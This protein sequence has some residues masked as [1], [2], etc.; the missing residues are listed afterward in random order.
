MAIPTSRTNEK[1][2]IRIDSAK[3]TGCGLCVQVCKDFSL[4]LENNKATISKTPAFGCIGCGHCMAICPT[5]AIEISGRELSIADLFD[6]PPVTNTANYEQLFAL[7]QRRRSVREFLDKEVDPEV[8]KKILCAA[9]TSPMGLPPSDVNVLIL[10]TKEKTRMF[11]VDFCEYL[12]GMK[13]FVSKWFLTVMRP[14]WGKANDELFRG[15]V[16]P[17]FNLYI[18]GLGQG[19]NL[20][21][22]DAPLAMYFYGS[23]YAD[24]A[25]PI[26][27]ATTAMYAAESLGLGTCMLGAIHPLIQNGKKAKIFREKHGIKYASREGLFVIFGYSAVKYRKGIKRTFASTNILHK[28]QIISDNARDNNK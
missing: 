12:K 5:G 16:R 1:A 15:F 11:A 22:Y 20:V 25:D 23:P 10:D 2:S 3:C 6:L 7:F 8:A 4:C 24:P 13:W 14:F 21:N 9:R 26:V 28:Q 18:N 17:A 27:A 19:I